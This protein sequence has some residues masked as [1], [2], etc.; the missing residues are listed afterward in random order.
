MRPDTQHAPEAKKRRK[1]RKT[2]SFTADRA[3]T[4]HINVEAAKEDDRDPSFII[5]KILRRHFGLKDSGT[6]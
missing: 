2:F 1:F 6:L 4:T 3:L 5:R